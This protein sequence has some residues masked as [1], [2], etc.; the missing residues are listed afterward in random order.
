MASTTGHATASF[1]S[2]GSFLNSTTVVITGQTGITDVSFVEAWLNIRATAEHSVDE[3][4]FDPIEVRAGNIVPGT[5]FTIYCN[6]LDGSAYGNY[7]I[8]WVWV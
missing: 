2:I 5:G 6:M 4:I 7:V 1:G 3:I 8:D